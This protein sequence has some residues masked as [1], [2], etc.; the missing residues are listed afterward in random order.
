MKTAIIIPVK[1]EEQGLWELIHALLGQI[2]GD[3]EIIFVDAGSKDRTQEILT[4]AA[5]EHKHIRMIISPG[6][7]PGKGRNVGIA[8]TDADI[9]LQID[10]AN[11]PDDQ[12]LGRMIAPIISGETAY[13][14]G[15]FRYMPIVKKVFNLTFNIAEVYGS[16]LYRNAGRNR[17]EKASGGQCAAYKRWIWEKAG[18]FPEWTPV[19]E[20]KLFIKK[21]QDLNVK[22]LFVRDAYIYW[23]IGPRLIDVIKRQINNQK[24]KFIHKGEL[25]KFSG[26]TLFPLF[27][28][29]C[30]IFSL[31]FPKFLPCTVLAVSAYSLRLSFKTYI[32]Y[33]NYEEN[34]FIVHYIG[35]PVILIIEFISIFSKIIGSV[36]GIINLSYRNEFSR[37]ANDYLQSSPIKD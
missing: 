1:N 5:K 32:D 26:F 14:W 36:L 16:S 23:Q 29:A 22:M 24:V 6:A 34:K 3:D 2:S 17:G 30:I 11:M 18:G 9:I 21:L 20:D 19:A 7:F 10:G 12:W 31:I 35:A 8:S 4:Q 37:R 28:L 15:N 33:R 25:F 13:V 27:I